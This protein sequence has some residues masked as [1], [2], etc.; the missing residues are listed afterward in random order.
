[1]SQ[2]GISVSGRAMR[3][4]FWRAPKSAVA[5]TIAGNM[6][7]VSDLGRRWLVFFVFGAYLWG[8]RWLATNL[9]PPLRTITALLL[10]LWFW[11]GINLVRW[12][13][14]ARAQAARARAMQR[15]M[16]QT[17][18]ALPG[19]LQ[20]LA[21]QAIPQTGGFTVPGML[22]RDDPVRDEHERMAREQAE[23]VRQWTG[24]DVPTGDKFEPLITWPKF[25][26]RHKKDDDE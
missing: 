19:Q 17:L 12:T 21:R 22:R 18:N 4:L 11:H 6:A 20:Q 13:L 26:R 1:V 25:L 3:W 16:Y 9:V 15:E 8:M 2:G 23:Q 7:L 10:L 14:H 5:Y 24:G